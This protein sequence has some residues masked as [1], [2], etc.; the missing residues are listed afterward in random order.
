M[1]EFEKA[2]IEKNI[3]EMKIKSDLMYHLNGGMAV[4]DLYIE[5]ND[6]LNDDNDVVADE[7]LASQ[8]EQLDMTKLSISNERVTTFYKKMVQ[9][10]QREKSNIDKIFIQKDEVTEL[11]LK[12]IFE[13]R[14][15]NFLDIYLHESS[16]STREYLYKLYDALEQSHNFLG[17]SLV[18]IEGLSN[19]SIE[20]MIEETFRDDI[21]THY[22]TNERN[23][24]DEIF[25]TNKKEYDVQKK[26]FKIDKPSKINLAECHKVLDVEVTKELLREYSFSN[27]RAKRICLPKDLPGFIKT[28][29]GLCLKWVED[30]LVDVSERLL[31]LSQ[32][33]QVIH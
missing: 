19:K 14:I 28:M 6:F 32:K 26:T 4:V 8:K 23:F 1:R 16:E 13:Y 31:T 5:N 9:Q 12:N 18:N 2:F 7:K 29:F 25:R 21:V 24:V 3:N 27:Q 20:R 10:L 30:V 33:C 11:M 22:R 17:K 15:Q